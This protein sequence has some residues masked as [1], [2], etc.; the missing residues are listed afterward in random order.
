MISNRIEGSGWLAQGAFAFTVALGAVLSGCGQ[1]PARVGAQ[2]REGAER[3]PG[4][5]VHLIRPKGFSTASSFAGFQDINTQCSVVVM[6]MAAPFDTIAEGFADK[7]A[8][9]AQGM[10]V[11][12]RVPMDQ[13]TYPGLLY[14][15]DQKT[16]AANVR[17]WVWAF[18]NETKCVMV[19][20]ICPKD[21]VDTHFRELGNAVRSAAWEPDLVLD[22]ASEFGFHSE[23]TGCLVAMAGAG[24]AL[25]YSSDDK[26]DEDGK[27]GKPIFI[28]APSIQPVPTTPEEYSQ[29]RL[30]ST[31]GHKKVIPGELA[32]ITV[33]GLMGFECIATSIHRGTGEPSFIYQVMLFEGGSYWIMTGIAR[34]KDRDR[35]LPI[36]KRMARSFQRD[37]ETVVSENGIISVE[38]P[39]SWAMRSGLTEGAEL[40][41]GNPV[42]DVYLVAFSTAKN[43]FEDDYT[44]ED[45]ALEMRGVFAE[46]ARYRGEATTAQINGLETS[47][48]LL[49]L[50]DDGLPTAYLHVTIQGVNHYHE[51][52]MWCVE[53][54]KPYAM[55]AFRRILNSFREA[56]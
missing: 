51:V 43:T 11:T 31:V 32:D 2:V 37:H 47:Q 38:L 53:K 46:G 7:A 35:Y 23:D 24:K 55:P 1:E 41:A 27:E 18:G 17:K 33:A 13:G 15:V 19:L 44:F 50:V 6:E 12:D 26:P 22:P 30:R 49:G 16:P 4:T 28:V 25:G 36:F 39:A 29:H 8:L 21:L 10:V 56:K 3:V 14:Q 20:G 52:I 42:A 34:E 5:L 40:Q 9:K 45:Y 48:V 54:N